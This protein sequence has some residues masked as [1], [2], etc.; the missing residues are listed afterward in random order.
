MSPSM[1][2]LQEYHPHQRKEDIIACF[3]RSTHISKGHDY[4]VRQLFYTQKENLY[5][6]HAWGW[7]GLR[8]YQTGK[9]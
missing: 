8:S 7:I 3:L 6:E 4:N 9:R 1:M 5:M 2:K